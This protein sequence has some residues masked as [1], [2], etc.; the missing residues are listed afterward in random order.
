MYKKKDVILTG[1]ALFAMLFGAGNLIFPPMVGYVVG[2]Q[3][4]SAAAGFFITGI[5]FPLLAILSSALAGKE[6]DDF[7]DKVSPLFSKIFNVVLILAIGPFLAIPRTG[8]TA[9]ELMLLPHVDGNNGMYKYVFLACYFIIVFLFSIKANAVIERIGKILTPVLLII[10]AVIVVKGVFFP[11]GEPLAKDISNTFRYGFYNGYQTMDT[12]AAIIF[13]SIILKAIRNGRNLTVKQEM[14]FLSNS[15]MIAVCGLS[16][17]YGGLLYIG[18]TS[19]GVLHSTGTTQLL[20]D[21]VNKLLGKEGNLALGVCVAGACLTTAI[22]LT[23]TVGDYFSNLLKTSY[24]KVVTATVVLSFI[25]AGFGV[26]AIVKVSAPILT[27]LYPVA[28]VLIVLNCFKK[29]ISSDKTYLGAVIGAGIIGFFEM[30]QTLGINLQ[31][32]NKIYIKLPL[33]TFGLAWVVPS[34]I[35]AVLFS[36]LFKKK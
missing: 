21:I 26:D 3:W 11:I 29:Y 33:Q 16:L 17:V 34:L 12:L 1:F 22:G 23:A 8:A 31:F 15:S 35:F 6:L 32:L 24:E 13:S 14:S 18:A 10:L 27:F 20:T 19:Y 36:I 5:G 30:T 9:F 28:I 4:I 7:A 2:D 25:F